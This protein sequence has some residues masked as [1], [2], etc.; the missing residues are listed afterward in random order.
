MLRLKIS[1]LDRLLHNIKANIGDYENLI[2]F[3]AGT[4]NG[5]CIRIMEAL[6]SNRC[7]DESER[8]RILLDCSSETKSTG[9]NVSSLVQRCV[10]AQS[11]VL[12]SPTVYTVVGMQNLPMELKDKVCTFSFH[13][14]CLQ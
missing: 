6:L 13:K 2:R 4:D 3:A 5:L 12:K 9:G 14:I 11:I 7:L 10:T 1:K 8:Y